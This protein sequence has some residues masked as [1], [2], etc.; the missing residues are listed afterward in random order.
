MWIKVLIKSKRQG[1]GGGWFNFRNYQKCWL[2]LTKIFENSRRQFGALNLK[3][4]SLIRIYANT[5]SNVITLCCGEW[6]M[7][8]I[9]WCNRQAKKSTM[10]LYSLVHLKREHSQCIKY[11]IPGI[12]NNI[13]R[14]RQKTLTFQSE[15]VS[16][17]IA[18]DWIKFYFEKLIITHI[19]S[20]KKN[21][22]ANNRCVEDSNINTIAGKKKIQKKTLHTHCTDTNCV[23]K[24]N[25]NI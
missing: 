11:T 17:P 12:N 22:I 13:E 10:L 16:I 19:K 9:M 2:F 21:K 24:T 25:E 15:S 8:K 3:R 23:F 5:Y 14:Q 4:G 7:V 20:N 6:I 18:I 1:G